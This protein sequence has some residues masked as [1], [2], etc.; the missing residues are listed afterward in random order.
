MQNGISK[1][2]VGRVP[3]PGNPA[4]GLS[5]LLDGKNLDMPVRGGLVD[6]LD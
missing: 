4:L 5:V 6:A 1:S 3:H 2:Q